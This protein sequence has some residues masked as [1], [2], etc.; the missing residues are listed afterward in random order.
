MSFTASH[1]DTMIGS[2]S[3]MQN[4]VPQVTIFFW[5]IKILA[6]TVGRPPPIS[7]QRGCTS[8]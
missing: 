7:S 1:P 6:T 2:R 4:K 8:A 3:P 5:I